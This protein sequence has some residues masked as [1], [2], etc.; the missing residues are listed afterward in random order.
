MED[1]KEKISVSENLEMNID[2]QPELFVDKHEPET[3]GDTTGILRRWK[4]K[5][6]LRRGSLGLR[7]IALFMSLISLILTASNKHGYWNNFDKFEEYR[8]MLAVAALSSLY[9]V[10]QVFRQ[11]HELFTGK[12]LMRPKTEGLIDFVGD[13]VV[14]YLL[15]SSTSSA[16]PATD[17]MREVTT[18]IFTDSAAAG[19]AFS[20]FAFCCL[21]L[22][23]VISG[24]KLSTQTYT[25]MNILDS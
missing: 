8:Y 18:N 3:G 12:S 1:Q 13:Q 16:I 17:E 11:V 14:A 7:G 24:Y 9:T 2:V 5:E 15:I 10:V 19:I 4:R 25:P 21:A 22:S 20:F 23:A 6:M